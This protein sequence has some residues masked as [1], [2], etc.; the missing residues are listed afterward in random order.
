MAS[1][2]IRPRSRIFHGHDWV[3]GTEVQLTTGDPQPGDIVTLKDARNRPLGSAIYNPQSKIVARR[4]SRQRQGLDPDFFKRRLQR[5]LD[6][7]QHIGITT[8]LCRLVWSEADGLP[9]VVVDIYGDY[10]VLQTNTLAMDN[11][12]MEIADA[13]AET[14]PLKGVVE[15]ND[16]PIRKGEGLPMRTGMLHGTQ[17]SPFELDANSI[18][19]RVDLMQ[20]QK[21]G[22]YLDQLDNYLAVAKYAPNRTVLDCFANQ[23]GFA[24]H[25]AKAGA[26]SVTAI[27][28]STEATTD[29]H[30]NFSRNNL[31]AEIITANVFDYL[32]QQVKDDK[33]QNYDLIILDPPSFTRNRKGLQSALRGYKEIHLQ[34]LKLL[35]P[36]GIL[37]TYTCSHHIQRTDF[38]EML[39]DASVDA[40][41]TLRQLE[42]HT[43]RLDHP[44]IPAIP[45]T[46]YLKG[47]V[48]EVAGG[49]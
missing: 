27:D 37:A 12:R 16:S 1:L 24:L 35:R 42:S 15:R 47:F 49:W 32:R 11:H 29:M 25:A 38:L 17:P 7:R 19:Y 18:T 2:V 26:K 21:T 8:D 28:I 23:G 5:A 36:G 4:I 9:G 39:V 30:A 20:G 45:E 10:A 31:T 48:F 3:Y 34:A 43:Q 13:L 41:R 40:K 44:V 14:L 6:F 46:E 22:L 33:P